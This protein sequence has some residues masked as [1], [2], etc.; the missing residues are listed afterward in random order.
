MLTEVKLLSLNLSDHILKQNQKHFRSNGCYYDSFH[1]GLTKRKRKGKGSPPPVLVT[2]ANCV[3]VS[4]KK[5][6]LPTTLKYFV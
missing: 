1:Q 3:P 5:I 6:A 4:K 2:R